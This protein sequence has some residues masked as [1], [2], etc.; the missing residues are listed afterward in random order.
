MSYGTYRTYLGGAAHELAPAP[1]EA[2]GKILRTANANTRIGDDRHVC[3]PPRQQTMARLGANAHLVMATRD[4]ERLS[5]L[6]GP[7]AEPANVFDAPPFF[8]E[9]D[10]ASWFESPD[11]DQAAALTAFHE[12][13]EHPMDA[14]I[15]INVNRTGTIA[16]DESA[17]A[18]AG[19]GVARLV[20][21]RQISL[22]FDD[23]P[24][25]FSPDQFGP[26]QLSRA[27]QRVA[28]EKRTR[29]KQALR[30][31]TVRSKSAG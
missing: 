19:E 20:V 17:G 26:D 22:R 6:A 31:S 13:V 11:Q 15:K 4:L 18:G 29:Q 8:H 23:E 30:H 14:V 9:R 12:Q 28:L 7:G 1:G 2:P 27:N 25:A 10:S 21:Q 3:L 5:E 16:F 24:G